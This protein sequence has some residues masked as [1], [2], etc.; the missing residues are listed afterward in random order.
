MSIDTP[1]D[2]PDPDRARICRRCGN[3]FDPREGTLVGPEGRFEQG[4]LLGTGTV[5][6]FQCNRCSRIRLITQA[7]IWGS[8]IGLV[9][10][11]WLL[12]SL[13]VIE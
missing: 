2:L 11:V 10:L 6:R 3:W 9:A 13:G 4:Y 12:V 5:L 7:I 1:I 8:F